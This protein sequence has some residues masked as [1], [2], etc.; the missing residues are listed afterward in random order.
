MYRNNNNNS[1]SN[2]NFNLINI[3]HMLDVY[4]VHSRE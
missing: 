3:V 2:N 4:D 1:S